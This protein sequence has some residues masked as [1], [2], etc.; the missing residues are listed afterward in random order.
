VQIRPEEILPIV[1]E[2][3]KICFLDIEVTSKDGDYGSVLVACVKPFRRPVK[4][5]VVRRPG[6]DE[7]VLR[8]VRRELGQ[9]LIWVSFYGKNFDIPFLNTR[10]WRYGLPPLERK[11]HIDM[12]WVVKSGTLTGRRSQA[13]LLEFLDSPIRKLTISPE[14]W[15]QVVKD[16]SGKALKILQERCE[17]DVCGL[18]VLYTRSRKLIREITR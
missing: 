2:A 14:V 16:R 15:N 9:Y 11:H 4:S 6:D 13:H 8:A 10:L 12:Y 1:E 17:K 3:G 18:E 7:S 5:F